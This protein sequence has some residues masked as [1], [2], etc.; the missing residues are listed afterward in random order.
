[1]LIVY[2]KIG[3]Q[4]GY[5]YVA[6]LDQNA[7]SYRDA[8]TDSNFESDSDFG[9]NSHSNS[10]ADSDFGADLSGIDSDENFIFPSL[11]YRS[12]YQH[13]IASLWL[14]SVFFCRGQEALQKKAHHTH[15]STH[16][17]IDEKGKSDVEK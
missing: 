8:E 4:L 17:T 16:H 6:Q 15:T 10:G 7:Y 14:W 12:R 13:H 3:L 1:M 11:E 5:Q 2:K 9:A